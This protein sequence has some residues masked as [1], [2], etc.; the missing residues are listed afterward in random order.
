MISNQKLVN[1]KVLDLFGPVILKI[2]NLV[3]SSLKTANKI[4][5]YLVVSSQAMLCLLGG[6]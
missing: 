6:R 4:H 2:L 1:K 5:F 3:G